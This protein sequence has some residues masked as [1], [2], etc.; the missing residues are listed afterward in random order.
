MTRRLT[1]LAVN[2]LCRKETIHPASA[3]P[4][5]GVLVRFLSDFLQNDV[6]MLHTATFGRTDAD[7]TG[8]QDRFKGLRGSSKFRIR[9]VAA[10][11]CNK[12]ISGAFRI[13][14]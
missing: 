8:V 12:C 5:L 1:R 10:H 9:V 2:D 7:L 13:S 6:S 11:A 4:S 3:L 14:R